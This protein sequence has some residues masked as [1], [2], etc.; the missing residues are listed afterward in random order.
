MDSSS[1]SRSEIYIRMIRYDVVLY[2]QR[3]LCFSKYWVPLCT[4]ICWVIY[5]TKSTEK[6]MRKKRTKGLQEVYDLVFGVLAR[7]LRTC[8]ARAYLF[9]PV[10]W[11]PVVDTELLQHY[12]Q[13]SRPIAD[14]NR[15]L[16]AHDSDLLYWTCFAWW[17]TQLIY[18]VW[19]RCSCDFILIGLI[20]S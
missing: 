4:W 12:E 1:R 6:E 5:S 13:L 9:A 15:C 20:Y 2:W 16:P 10:S 17:S 14:I 18:D 19:S 3:D 7:R 11:C 8:Q